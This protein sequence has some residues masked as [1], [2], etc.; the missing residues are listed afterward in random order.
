M[1]CNAKLKLGGLLIAACTCDADHAGLHLDGDRHI[2]WEASETL[3]DALRRAGEG[4]TYPLDL[5]P[6]DDPYEI[7]PGYRKV[8]DAEH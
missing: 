2:S 6:L 5:D 1:T 8:Q 7:L 4:Q 3:S